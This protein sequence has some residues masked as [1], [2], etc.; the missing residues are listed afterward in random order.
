MQHQ[1][2]NQQLYMKDTTPEFNSTNITTN[3]IISVDLL[4]DDSTSPETPMFLNVKS[5][6]STSF[7]AIYITFPDLLP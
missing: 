3:H 5:L 2:N 6:R 7:A 1:H 4:E